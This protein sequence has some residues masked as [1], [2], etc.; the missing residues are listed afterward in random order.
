MRHTITVTPALYSLG[1][2]L[3]DFTAE[4]TVNWIPES[5]DGWNEPR[6][7]AYAELDG[8]KQVCGP[9]IEPANLSDWADEWVRGNQDF[10]RLAIAEA[11]GF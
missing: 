4:I 11:R 3:C 5:G 1:I 7:A 8:I 2:E 9:Y 6:S 10:I